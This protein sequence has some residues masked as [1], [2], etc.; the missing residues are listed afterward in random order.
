[1]IIFS[2]TPMANVMD[3][4]ST[5]LVY[6]IEIIQQ[7]DT[8]MIVIGHS[9]LSDTSDIVSGSLY[10]G[11]LLIYS[12]PIPAVLIIRTNNA[13]FICPHVLS[14]RNIIYV[15]FDILQMSNKTC[16]ERLQSDG[17]D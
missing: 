11:L 1:M 13:C 2:H 9:E 16:K 10:Y 12:Y 4:T 8:K 17:I 3:I 5:I 14:I 15:S 7:R 6:L